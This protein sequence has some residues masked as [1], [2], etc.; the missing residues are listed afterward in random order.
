MSNNIDATGIHVQTLADIKAEL[1]AAYKAIYGDD[2]AIDSD[3]PDGQLIGIETQAKADMLDFAVQVYNS[4]DVDA[5][6]GRS[7]DVLYK[8]NNIFRTS[9]K[10]SFVQV[11]V[12][13]NQAV[14]L[15][16]LD[17]DI[18]NPDGVG[19]T[20]SNANG[21]LFILVNSVSLTSAG[22]YLLEFR[23]KELGAITATVNSINVMSTV[24]A[25]VVSVN[26]P[27]I[28]YIT[29]TEEEPDVDFR[30]RRNKSTTINGQG[31]YDALTAQLL[32]LDNVDAA[33]VYENDTSSTDSDGTLEHTIWCIVRGGLDADIAKVIYANKT[34]G[35]GLRGDT[36]ALVTKSDGS[37]ILI[38]FDR[39]ASEDLY[40]NLEIRVKNPAYSPDLGLIKSGLISNLVYEIYES[41]DVTSIASEVIQ[42]DSGVIVKTCEISL[43]GSTWTDYLIPTSK[44]N[45]FALETAHIAITVV[46]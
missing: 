24:V 4:H 27:A 18:D 16:G 42:I 30:I 9:A 12:T 20:V 11:N 13:V 5:V 40:I 32:Q 36:T 35:C 31:F 39:P 43:N 7:Q 33:I 14:N 37:T 15:S 29:G 44:K 8:L 38:K 10:F 6:I 22:T 2:I 26:N 3:T 19:Y 1:E 17:D 25:G 45:F 21:D 23:A 41:A 34:F 46:P 28:Q